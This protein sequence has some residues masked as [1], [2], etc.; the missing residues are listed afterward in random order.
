MKWYVIKVASGKEKKIKEAIEHELKRNSAE[1]IISNLLIPYSKEIQIRKGKKI[2][3]EKNSFPGYIFVECE[4][5]NEVESYVKHISGVASVLKQPISAFEINR[6]LDK[7]NKKENPDILY[8]NQKVKIID[9]P[10]NTFSGTIKTL[11]IDK[12]K[13]KVS[14]SVFGREVMLDLSFSQ[15]MKES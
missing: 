8:I 6:I 12:Q 2:N 1:K 3:V 7:E 10:F 11:D 13:S 5:I 4:S 15:F 9:G 14:V